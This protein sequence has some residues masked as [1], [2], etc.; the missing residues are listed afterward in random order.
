[1]ALFFGAHMAIFAARWIPTLPLWTTE[2]VVD[3]LVISLAPVLWLFTVVLATWLPYSPSDKTIWSRETWRG[4]QLYALCLSPVGCMLRFYLVLQFSGRIP[5]FQSGTFFANV[6]GTM[7]LGIA[8]SLQHATIPVSNLI[9][10][11]GSYTACQLLQAVM[12]GL[13]G[14]LTT[15]NTWVLEFSTFEEGMLTH[16]VW[17]AL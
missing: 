14:S 7:V 4:P 6:G 5:S 1:M 2:R 17:Q 12:E 8:F 16:T 11:G 15:V 13:C 9:L 10:G 3:S